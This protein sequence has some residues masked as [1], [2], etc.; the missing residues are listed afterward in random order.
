MNNDYHSE[1]K[2]S[3]DADLISFIKDAGESSHSGYQRCK[4]TRG[5]GGVQAVLPAFPCSAGT[6]EPVGH[7]VGTTTSLLT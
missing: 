1:D 5:L 6:D 2:A 3:S 7:T 4:S